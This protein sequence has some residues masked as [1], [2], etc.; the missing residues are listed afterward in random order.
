M[1][2]RGR[3]GRKVSSFGMRSA[4]WP[5]WWHDLCRSAPVGPLAHVPV[6]PSVAQ[7]CV[8][9][10]LSRFLHESPIRHTLACI[11]YT[12]RGPVNGAAAAPATRCEVPSGLSLTPLTPLFSLRTHTRVGRP[13]PVVWS[14]PHCVPGSGIL[15]AAYARLVDHAHPSFSRLP[16]ACMRFFHPLRCHFRPRAASKPS[17]E[18]R[19]GVCQQTGSDSSTRSPCWS[20]CSASSLWTSTRTA[21]SLSLCVLRKVRPD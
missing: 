1:P 3:R 16:C 15:V 18:G 2:F 10:V 11:T 4:G 7:L 6:D 12:F 14:I 19:V 20:R 9:I 17:V 21:P 5:F 13:S 8:V